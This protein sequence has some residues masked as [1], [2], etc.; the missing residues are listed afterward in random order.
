MRRLR[1]RIL[2]TLFLLAI[3]A[4]TVLFLSLLPAGSLSE[5]RRFSDYCK[6]R[7]QKEAV[8]SAL[9]LHYTL[10]DPSLAGI[11]DYPLSFGSVACP[12]AEEL[13]VRLQEEKEALAV[14]DRSLLSRKNRLLLDVLLYELENQELLASC[15]FLQEPLGPSLGIQAQLPILLAE[16][17]FRT[18]K[19]LTEYL[20]LLRDLPR[21]FEEILVFEEK[22]AALGVFMSDACVDGIVRQCREFVSDEPHFLQEIF[23]EKLTQLSGLS[24]KEREAA[25]TLHQKLLNNCIL[26]A[27]HRL[28]EGLSAL[29][30]AAPVSCGLAQLPGG[31]DYYRFLLR[32]QTGVDDSPAALEQRLYAQMQADSQ[33][34]AALTERNPALLEDA[35]LP[36]LPFS[37]P[38]A[39]L[40]ELAEAIETDFP[41]APDVPYEVKTVTP[42]L[43]K[44]LS[45]AFYLTPPID[46]GSPNSI[47]LNET[48]AMSPTE[49]YTTLAHE[50]FPGHLYQTIWF[51]RSDAPLLRHLYSFGGYVEGW[52]T[53]VETYAYGY[54][55]RFFPAQADSFR[56]AWLNRSINLCLYSLLDLGIHF[57]GWTQAQTTAF[58]A[59]FGVT[60]VSVCQE[61]F[62]YIVETPGNYLKYYVGYLHFL[63]LKE[64]MKGRQGDDFSLRE[65]H[66]KI[67][68]TGPAPFAL[69]EKELRQD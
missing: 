55:A 39:M 41:P 12:S 22:K 8:S 65:F 14:F 66:R 11:R 44:F 3:P 67:L 29:R 6:E 50:G 48:A 49:L 57:H 46:A 17:A 18:E 4:A 36:A 9:T 16:Y 63:D 35:S 62:Q 19:D 54:A 43:A 27:Y 26:P 30:G 21:Y 5:N 47:Y 24:Q 51:A 34:I 64:E 38:Q 2:F 60:D 15:Y 45:P 53:Y 61:I 69:L 42:A 59:S 25:A 1:Q 7:F 31:S 28:I 52:A 33:E 20:K 10:A 56:L 23:E 68:E 32:S 37:S 13:A 40:A 58:L